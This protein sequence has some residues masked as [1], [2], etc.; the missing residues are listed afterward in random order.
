M[1]G[2]IQGRLLPKYKG[3]YQAHPVG[4]WQEEFSIAQDLGLD[5]IEFILDY[6]DV[7]SNPL[8]S[9]NGTKELLEVCE[10]TG[11][12]VHTICADYFMEAPLHS[13]DMNVA[14]HS[15]MIFHRLLESAQIL[16]VTDIVLPCVDKS[17]LNDQASVN[18]LQS[19]LKRISKTLE[20][21]NIN[22][23][24]ESNLAPEPFLALL[25]SCDSENIT[26]NYDT[27]NSASLGYDVPTEFALYGSWIT[28]VH[29]KD[30]VLNGGSV[31]LGLGHTN[32]DLVF[33]ELKT[34]H[35]SGPVI[36]QAYRDDEGIEIFKKQLE[37]IK[38]YV[39]TL[40]L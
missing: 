37:W 26:V 27:G 36:L 30:R 35:Y 15:Y 39:R 6:N 23:C 8:V 14:D 19:V 10:R 9:A 12:L 16:G 32:F 25:V 3:R 21:N 18:R 2:V 7:E 33:N 22:I 5:C 1:L 11:V 28:D 24:L 40:S 34:L 4:Y 17:A 38:P 13:P 20:K 31:Q 29:I